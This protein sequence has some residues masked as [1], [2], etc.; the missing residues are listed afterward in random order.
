MLKWKRE[1]GGILELGKRRSQWG[2]QIAAG[3]EELWRRGEVWITHGV[4]FLGSVTD[5]NGRV[6]IYQRG[7][8]FLFTLKPQLRV[9]TNKKETLRGICLLLI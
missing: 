7:D 9:H 6:R 2:G 1:E 5:L 4:F 8:I 3:L